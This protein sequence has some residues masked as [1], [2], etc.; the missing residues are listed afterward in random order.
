[1]TIRMT[2]TPYY[3]RTLSSY[4]DHIITKARPSSG[5]WHAVLDCGFDDG[6]GDPDFSPHG[7]GGSAEEAAARSAKVIRDDAIGIGKFAPHRILTDGY[8]L[9]FRL[10]KHWHRKERLEAAG[11]NANDML[12]AI[13]KGYPQ[14]D[15]QLKGNWLAVGEESRMIELFYQVRI[16]ETVSSVREGT[17]ELDEVRHTVLHDIKKELEDTRFKASPTTETWQRLDERIDA[18][19]NEMSANIALKI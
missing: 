11:V 6:P 5:G 19:I 18:A 12:R 1:M 3:E 9:K 15:W 7:Y 13:E 16:A 2:S 8:D 4:A 17:L 14:S 10:M